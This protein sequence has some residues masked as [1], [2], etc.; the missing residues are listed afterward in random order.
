MITLARVARRIDV[1]R[2]ALCAALLGII[3]APDTVAR[4]GAP[5]VA[6]GEVAGRVVDQFDNVLPAVEVSLI[7]A[8]G[9]APERDDRRT[10]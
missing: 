6:S 5:Q 9:P 3:A 2:L 1:H 10:G 8:R 7:A 4:A